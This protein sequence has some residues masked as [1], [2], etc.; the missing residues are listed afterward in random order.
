MSDDFTINIRSCGVKHG[1]IEPAD[2]VI[3]V[4]ELANPYWDEELRPYDGLN[5]RVSDYVLTAD[6]AEQLI[7]NALAAIARNKKASQAR[8][9]TE[10]KVV[11]TCTGGRHRSVAV[12]EEVGR[13][14]NAAGMKAVVTHRDR[15]LV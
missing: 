9:A 3:D 10:L 14:L 6:G 2:M 8:G 4:R 5:P 15:T 11:F 12:S 13:R 1:G 7:E